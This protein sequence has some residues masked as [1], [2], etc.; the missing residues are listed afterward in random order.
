MA[1]SNYAENRIADALFRNFPLAAPSA[2]HVGLLTAAPDDEGIVAGSEAAYSGYAR[3]L[4]TADPAVWLGTGG[5]AA[6]PSMGHEGFVYNA[7]EVIFGADPQSGPTTVTHLALFDAAT[8][9]NMW[10]YTELLEPKTINT[11]D[12]APAI[13]AAALGVR[14]TD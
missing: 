3:A 10:F 1:A 11:G 13:P 8:G 2:W 6:D 7:N 9:G 5:E 4:L 14:P 12:P